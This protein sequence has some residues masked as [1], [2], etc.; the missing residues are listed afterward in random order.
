MVF[1]EHR[2][3]L[4]DLTT[5]RAQALLKAFPT[6][7]HLAGATPQQILEV[8]QQAGARGF[9]PEEATRLHQAARDSI[10]SGKAREARAQ[11]V[12]TLLTQIERLSAS[13]EELD[14]AMQALLPPPEADSGPSDAQLLVSIPGIG[15]KTAAVLLGELGRLQR[16]KSAKA[17]V[18]YVGYYPLIEQSGQRQSP[19]RLSPAGSPVA[20]H[21]LYLAAVN[22]M[23]RSPQ[24]RTLYLR[25]RSQ[26]KSA[27]QAL[28][29]VAVKLLHTAYAL[30]QRRV[31][32]DPSRLL[33][34]SEVIPT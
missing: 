31:H 23:R 22:A 21:A 3:L 19:P 15:P 11:V 29:V 16:F 17:L 24:L 13:V 26:G 5:V 1:P 28:I 7:H 4:G 6:A 12:R 27:K 34:A 25:K 30:I 10:Y 2:T 18:A 20:R 9:T 33:V 8:A 32:Y 14:Q